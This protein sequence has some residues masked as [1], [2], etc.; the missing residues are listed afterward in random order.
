MEVDLDSL[1]DDLSQDGRLAARAF[2]QSYS[3]ALSPRATGQGLRRNDQT[4]AETL[5]IMAAIPSSAGGSRTSTTGLLFSCWLNAAGA[6]PFDVRQYLCY[7]SAPRIAATPQF[8][9]ERRVAQRC[10][11]EPRWADALLTKVL[12][13]ICKQHLLAP[14][15]SVCSPNVPTE[16]P[17]CLG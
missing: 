5:V 3:G 1:P 10:P 4:N 17:T 15:R 12:L 6:L 7:S 16:F 11:P 14:T 9:H 2:A 13:D 8:E